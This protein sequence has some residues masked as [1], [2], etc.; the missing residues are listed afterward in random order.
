M[1]GPR[2]ICLPT[3]R[4]CVS[5]PSLA[6]GLRL[7]A[8]SAEAEGSEG[9]LTLAAEHT[10]LLEVKKSKFLTHAFPITSAEEALAGF[11]ARRDAS[12]S[13]NC[14]AFRKERG[15]GAGQHYRSS[16]DGEPGGT[17]GRPILAA[18]EGEGLDGVAVLVVRWFGGVK[19]GA[20]GLVRAYGAAARE[21]LRAALRAR[22]TPRVALRLAVPFE[23]LGVTYALIEQH[24]GRKEGEEYGEGAV[25]MRLSLE[26]A[27]A[28][29]LAAALRDA[30]SGRVVAEVLEGAEAGGRGS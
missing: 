11:D 16:D 7:H 20:G 28:A 25:D 21:C 27:A 22:V 24:G 12:A 15:V 17:A 1:L 6:L 13:H 19:L 23:L 3:L 18:I 8:T 10:T 14:W 30:T 26:A 4:H 29:R 9:F 2:V 5:R